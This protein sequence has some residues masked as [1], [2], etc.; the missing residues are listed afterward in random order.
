MPEGELTGALNA[1]SAVLSEEPSDLKIQYMRE[2][3][4]LTPE[5][6]AEYAT[7]YKALMA[8]GIRSTAGGAAAVNANADLYELILNP[9]GSV[10]AAQVAMADVGEENEHYEAVRFVYEN[11]LMGMLDE[12]NFGVDEAAT[13]ADLAGALYAVIGGDAAA[14]DE[15][16][17]TLASYGILDPAATADGELTG[18]SAADILAV[19]SQAVGV[20]LAPEAGS[21]DALTRGELAELLMDYINALDE[22]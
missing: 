3:K 4:A 15:A 20:E 12:E 11:M 17:E 22:M 2:L 13:V 18:A 9:F 7:A 21:D 19:F 1:I 10:D 14:Q 5:K 16:V 6:L 8:E